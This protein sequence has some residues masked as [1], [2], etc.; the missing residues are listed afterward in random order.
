MKQVYMK[1][2]LLLCISC[3]IIFPG[4]LY[5]ASAAEEADGLFQNKKYQ[6]ALDIWYGLEQSGSTST[7]LY[8]NIGITESMLQHSPKAILAYEKA[9]RFSPS[10]SRIKDALV[11]ERKKIESNIIPVPDFFLFRWVRSIAS[12][13]RPGYWAMTGLILLLLPVLG[14]CFMRTSGFMSR[15]VLNQKSLIQV[16]ATGFIFLLLAGLSYHQI[17]RKDEAIIGVQCDFRQAP[18]A[19]S[20]QIRV[21]IAGEKVKVSDQ[22]GDWY[23]VRLLNL[24][25]GWVKKECLEFI[26]IDQVKPAKG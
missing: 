23:Q 13:L 3:S 25:E 14:Y 6:E 11:L 1:A 22:I 21:V 20:P 17:Y 16:L 5:A 26:L 10:N 8:Y 9:L 18:T 7:G 24:D 12:F 2:G 19:E 15:L 4:T